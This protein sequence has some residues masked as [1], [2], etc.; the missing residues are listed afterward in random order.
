MTEFT[1]LVSFKLLFTM[2]SNLF[3]SF[4]P[5]VFFVYQPLYDERYESELL[6]DLSLLDESQFLIAL[7]WIFLTLHSSFRETY[8]F[9]LL[10]NVYNLILLIQS[11]HK[12][13]PFFLALRNLFTAPSRLPGI[14]PRFFSRFYLCCLMPNHFLIL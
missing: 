6:L 8:L 9:E 3:I 13:F 7:A 11:F 12:L 2:W 5:V 14:P 10:H 1:W 4:R